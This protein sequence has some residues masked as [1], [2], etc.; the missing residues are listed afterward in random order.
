MAIRD[1]LQG[2]N[3]RLRRVARPVREI[4]GHIQGIVD[5]MIETL[6]N[7]EG[8]GL[9][10]PQVGINR[11]IVVVQI[12]DD[13]PIVLINPEIVS[14]E[15]SEQRLEGCLSFPGQWG[16][17]VR[18]ERVVVR[19]LDRDGGEHTY[20]GEGLLAQAFA[21]ELDHLDG[22]LFV[23]K[24]VSWVSEDDLRSQDKEAEGAARE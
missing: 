6:A 3:P 4:S 22:V 18:P 14:T 9:A 1:I 11:R 8:V 21:H 16:E 19:A 24:V 5:D 12:G 15:G 13:A 20:T 17:V 7:A 2:S 23:D 10:A